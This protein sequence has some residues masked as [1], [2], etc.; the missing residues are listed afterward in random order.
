MR[1]NF[2]II[3]AFLF[4]EQTSGAQIRSLDV[5]EDIKA[6]GQELK[7]NV[8][9]NKWLSRIDNYDPNMD[10]EMAND[11]LNNMRRQYAIKKLEDKLAKTSPGTFDGFNEFDQTKGMLYTLKAEQ[12]AVDA[13]SESLGPNE[14]DGT[15]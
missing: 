7:D 4:V 14:F 13:K 11:V 15:E 5:W 12:A 6:S 10:Q 1:T 9:E 8:L 3:A 2:A